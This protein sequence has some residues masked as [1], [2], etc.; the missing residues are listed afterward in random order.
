MLRSMENSINKGWFWCRKSDFYFLIHMEK[1]GAKSQN[2]GFI[3]SLH[4]IGP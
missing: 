1:T 2:L 4:H 3:E